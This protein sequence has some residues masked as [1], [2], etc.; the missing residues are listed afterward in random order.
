MSE[1][2]GRLLGYRKMIVACVTSAACVAIQLTTG[3]ATTA[4]GCYGALSGIAVAFCAANLYER[5]QG[6]KS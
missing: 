4:G 2:I 1:A 3:D 5:R 6:V